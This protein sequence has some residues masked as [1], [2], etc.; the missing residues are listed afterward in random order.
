MMRLGAMIVNPF[1]TSTVRFGLARLFAEKLG[2]SDTLPKIHAATPPTGGGIAA[3]FFRTVSEKQSFSTN[4]RRLTYLTA[5][6]Y[7]KKADAPFLPSGCL[8]ADAMNA[9]ISTI[10]R[11]NLPLIHSTPVEVTSISSSI[12]TPMFLYFS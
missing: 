11:G 6:A 10:E 12:R 3:M 4:T 5:T 8:D 1:E 7:G 2:F 9:S